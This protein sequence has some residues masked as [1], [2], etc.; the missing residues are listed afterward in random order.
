MTGTS[1]IS[2]QMKTGTNINDLV[3]FV[4]L[5][6]KDVLFFSG[7]HF[8]NSLVLMALKDRI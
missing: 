8:F 1:S 3:S 7:K 4:C 6:N 5:W 2:E